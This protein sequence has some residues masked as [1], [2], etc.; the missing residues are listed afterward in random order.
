MSVLAEVLDYFKAANLYPEDCWCFDDNDGSLGLD[1]RSADGTKFWLNLNRDGSIEI[2]W[3]PAGTETGKG[4]IV[5]FEDL[6]PEIKTQWRMS[7]L[8]R[9]AAGFR[10]MISSLR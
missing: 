2:Y 3:K 1:H 6:N 8:E 9:L 4:R 7:R 5:R 10:L